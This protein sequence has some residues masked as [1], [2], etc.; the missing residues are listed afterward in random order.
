MTDY[1][2]AR[3]QAAYDAMLPRDENPWCRCG[4]RYDSH[5]DNPDADAMEDA[6]RSILARAKQIQKKDPAASFS[7]VI[8]YAN[9]G[10]SVC[11]QCECIEFEDGEPPEPE[12][13]HD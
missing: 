2:L 6:L 9:A 10:L 13:E 5:H 7:W 3:A 11:D 4:D 12:Y 1:G 8:Q